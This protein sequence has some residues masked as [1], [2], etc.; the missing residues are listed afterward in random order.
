M[1]SLDKVTEFMYQHFESVTTSKR[2]DHFLAKCVLCG[3]SKTNSRK[4]RFNLDYNNG[5]PMYHCFN[6]NES[7]SFIDIYALMNG[8]SKEEAYDELY[9]YDSDDLKRRLQKHNEIIDWVKKYT[10]TDCNWIEDDCVSLSK[11][12]D[13]YVQNK[14]VEVLEKFY[15]DR[16]ISEKNK[17]FIAYKGDYKGR[18]I[19]P[20]Y[21]KNKSIIYF[22]A[23]RIPGSNILPKYKNPVVEKQNVILNEDKFKNNKPVV[24]VEG[25]ID[26]FSIGTQG[27][28][29]LGKEISEN[30]IKNIL[31]YTN[32]PIVCFDNDES[33]YK[34]LIT[35]MLGKKDKK[36]KPN[37]YSKIVNYFIFPD[38]YI[39]YKDINNIRVGDR[40]VNIYEMILKNSFS[41]STAYTKI[42]VNKNVK[43]R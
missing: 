10:D 43:W 9:S 12:I 23:R 39:K 36:K 2:G 13:G 4:R 26:A 42:Y 5:K 38:E 8:L 18:I 16:L 32:K 33:G 34:S 35:F 21:D 30:F 20:V 41:Y 7:G 22:Q 27:T 14:Y 37:K 17:I 24:I 1:I 11:K 25:L 29:C 31:K 3:D 19:I 6:C 28:S 15:K 40:K